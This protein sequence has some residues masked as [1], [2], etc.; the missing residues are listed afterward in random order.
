M[1]ELLLSDSDIAELSSYGILSKREAIFQHSYPWDSVHFD[2]HMWAESTELDVIIANWC[3]LNAPKKGYRADRLRIHLKVIVLNLFSCFR[4]HDGW[5][6]AYQRGQNDYS[7]SS[8]YNA[9]N[10]SRKYLVKAVNILIGLEL[11][12][13][14]IGFYDRKDKTNSKISRMRAT[15][16]LIRLMESCGKIKIISHP[17]RECIIKR[18]REKRDIEYGKTS[19]KNKKD[20]QLDIGMRNRLNTINSLLAST[21]IK[22]DM[23]EIELRNLNI[24]LRKAEKQEINLD[25]VFLRRVFNVSFKRGGRFYNGWWENVPSRYRSK[26]LID[27]EPTVELDYSAIHPSI[28]YLEET[29]ELPPCDPYSLTPYDG[30]PIM[31]KLVKSVF[32]ILLNAKSPTEAK[33]SLRKEIP[34]DSRL[35]DEAKTIFKELDLGE[36]FDHIKADHPAIWKYMG[37]GMG[38]HLQ[39]LDSCIAEHVLI[40]LAEKG[41]TALPV[42]DSFIV[43]QRHKS[44][45]KETMT[46]A[47]V[48][49]WGTCPAI[50]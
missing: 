4:W 16:D 2:L 11:I 50:S 23:P 36:V 34:K 25:K 18:D 15:M 42:H 32:L 31:R 5:Y 45:L 48:D 22:L 20:S 29:G 19:R 13:H 46:T 28:A 24:S 30:D 39:Y 37:Q 1:T 35:S 14:C 40:S 43:Q 41:I 44:I 7:P 12:D 38:T 27:G 10:I 6:V 49:R 26:I 8:R 3:A 47:F 9:L 17:S 33:K 21:D